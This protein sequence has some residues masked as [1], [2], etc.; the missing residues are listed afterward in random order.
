MMLSYQKTIYISRLYSAEYGNGKTHR[1]PSPAGLQK[2]KRVSSELFLS[3]QAL[4][5]S[6]KAPN[7]I[8]PRGYHKKSKVI[9]HDKISAAID[10]RPDE[11]SPSKIVS[12]LYSPL[13]QWR[14]VNEWD[15]YINDPVEKL[16]GHI[17]TELEYS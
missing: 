10:T 12:V 2:I 17:I 11:Y 4:V 6:F 14:R 9:K 5:N 1:T 7:L 13:W 15:R 3:L 8:T 16:N